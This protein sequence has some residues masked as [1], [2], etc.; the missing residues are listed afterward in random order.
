MRRIFEMID[1][2]G[3]LRDPM[4]AGLQT[5]IEVKDDLQTFVAACLSHLRRRKTAL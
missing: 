4:I 1:S 5:H 3:T 2:D